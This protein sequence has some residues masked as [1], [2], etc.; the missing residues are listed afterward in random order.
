MLDRRGE[1]RAKRRENE[2]EGGGGKGGW[3]RGA[4][5]FLAWSAEGPRTSPDSWCGVEDHELRTKR[6]STLLLE[7]QIRR[8][9]IIVCCLT[10]GSRAG[11]AACVTKFRNTFF[12]ENSA[13]F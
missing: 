8:L 1:G 3:G 10:I 9:L 7:V 2:G 13:R 4:Q 11:N 5:F 6:P 12:D